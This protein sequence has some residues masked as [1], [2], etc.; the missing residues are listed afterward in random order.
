MEDILNRIK[1]GED[2][3]KLI[4]TYS[5]SK[6]VKEKDGLKEN[7]SRGGDR[8]TPVQFVKAAFSVPVGEFSDV[9]R[10]EIGFHIVKVISRQEDTRSLAEVRS[11]LEKIIK[12]KKKFEIYNVY[13]E[14]LKNEVNYTLY[15]V[16]VSD[17]N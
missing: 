13:L 17:K 12:E 7:L 16:N 10:S 8:A 11:Q 3:I 5:D 6:N 9:I 2:F 4:R 14:E 15:P 1:K